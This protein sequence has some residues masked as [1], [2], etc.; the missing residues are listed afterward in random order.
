[1]E[2]VDDRSGDAPE[3]RRVD[4]PTVGDQIGEAVGG[5]SGVLAGAAIGSAGGPLGTLIGGIAGAIGGWWAGRAL[6]EAAERWTQEEE[7]EYRA[8]YE[9][10]GAREGTAYEDVRPAYQLGHLARHNPDYAGRDFEE[11]ED[12][13]ERGWTASARPS[14]PEWGAVRGYARAAYTRGGAS[15]TSPAA[16]RVDDQETIVAGDEE[17]SV[18]DGGVADRPAALGESDHDLA[19]VDLDAA[20]VGVRDRSR[21]ASAGPVGAAAPVDITPEE[22]DLMAR[23]RDVPSE[24]TG[25]RPA[26]SSVERPARTSGSEEAIPVREGEEG[27]AASASTFGNE[28]ALPDRASYS[29]PLPRSTDEESGEGARRSEERP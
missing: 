29:D 23:E 5:I 18:A 24:P 16:A 27:G 12:D 21:G 4:V 26:D 17:V 11:I 7:A 22:L 15:V 25:S 19:D 14:A 13:L 28:G 2:R 8:H 20:E 1:M 6:A 3:E 10:G 9:A